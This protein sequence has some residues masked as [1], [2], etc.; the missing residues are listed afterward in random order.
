[1]LSPA[2]CP[3]TSGNQLVYIIIVTI[4]TPFTFNNVY[5]CPNFREYTVYFKC[6]VDI[7]I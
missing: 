4:N 3:T 2:Q 5:C 7:H 6:L 1:M